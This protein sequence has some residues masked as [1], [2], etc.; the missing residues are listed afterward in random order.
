[1]P[2]SRVKRVARRLA[3]RAHSWKT[4]VGLT[5]SGNSVERVSKLKN[6][7]EPIMMI[8]GFGATRRTL[9]IIE[10]RL[11]NDGFTVFSVNLGGFLNTF[12]TDSIE[13]LA[14]HI[15]EKVERLYKKHHFRGKLTILGHSKGGLIGHYYI[16]KLGGAKRVKS[17]ITLGSPHNG[18]PWAM[19]ASFTPIGWVCKSLKQMS[20]IS[21]FIRHLKETEFPAGVKVFSIYSKDDTVC[22]YPVAVL[23]ETADVKNIEVFGVSHSEFLIKKNA[24]NAIKHALNDEIPLSWTDVSRKNYQE[25]LDEKKTRFKIIP[26]LK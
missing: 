4:I 20:P 9:G 26:G 24:Y 21:G 3:R 1:M 23:G 8:Y 16:K 11:Q 5:L 14:K 15:Q 10:K 6:C 18:N 19:I 2:L 12:N 25:H 7:R 22:P 17:L 13:R